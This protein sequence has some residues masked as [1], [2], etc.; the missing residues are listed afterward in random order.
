MPIENYKPE[1]CAHCG[2]DTSYVLGI[3]PGTAVIVKA[4]SAA[5]RAKG[6]N[7]I[8]PKKEM[9]VPARDWSYRLAVNEG[10]LT[11]TQIGNFTRARVHGLI[12]RI[13]GEPGNWCLTS[14]GGAFLRGEAV[15]RYAIVT[16]STAEERSHKEEYFEPEANQ[17]TIHE[18]NVPGEPM[19]EGISFEIREGRIVTKP[20]VKAKPPEPQGSLGV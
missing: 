11:S 16:K 13:K 19:W 6:I 5:I 2:Q 10:K 4:V 17:V 1:T 9:E 18:V 8:H 12:A 20:T 7:A 14:K 3:D 15:P